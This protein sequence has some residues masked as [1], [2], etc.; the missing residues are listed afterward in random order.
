MGG[1]EKDPLSLFTINTY[2]RWPL[3]SLTAFYITVDVDPQNRNGIDYVVYSDDYGDPGN[4]YAST[5]SSLVILPILSSFLCR[6]NE[7]CLSPYNNNTRFVYKVVSQDYVGSTQVCDGAGY[8]NFFSPAIFYNIDQ[9]KSLLDP[10]DIGT[11][12]NDCK[13]IIIQINA[14]KN[15]V[16]LNLELESIFSDAVTSLILVKNEHEVSAIDEPL[17]GSNEKLSSVD[18]DSAI[19][20]N[21]AVSMYEE[22]TS[23]SM[24]NEVFLD[25]IVVVLSATEGKLF[26]ANETTLT[27]ERTVST[28]DQY[29]VLHDGAI[30]TLTS[31]EKTLNSIENYPCDV[32][33]VASSSDAQTVATSHHDESLL[34][35]KF[36]SFANIFCNPVLCYDEFEEQYEYFTRCFDVLMFFVRCTDTIIKILQDTSF[37]HTRSTINVFLGGDIFSLHATRPFTSAKTYIH[38]TC[39][40]IETLCDVELQHFDTPMA[41]DN[42]P[43]IDDAQFLIGVPI[44]G[45]SILFGDNK[46]VVTSCSARSSTLKRRHNALAYQKFKNVLLQVLFA[47][48]MLIANIRLLISSRSHYLGI[49]FDAIALVYWLNHQSN[50]TTIARFRGGVRIQASHILETHY[51]TVDIPY[52]RRLPLSFSAL[53]SRFRIRYVG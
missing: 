48:I 5:D 28:F 20:D 3:P 11:T 7:P 8:F 15:E 30:K 21:Y 18:N 4:T 23:I 52:V 29:V 38:Q 37:I 16:G 14:I 39:K 24:E 1:N 10:I 45:P 46:S 33:Y 17:C 25:N 50:R 13:N 41:T 19:I 40:K 42:H 35:V 36:V 31:E 27:E 43:E 6:T 26:G 51:L 2:K 34:R 49:V 9:A 22:Q 47:F 32:I 44:I 53:L 12:R